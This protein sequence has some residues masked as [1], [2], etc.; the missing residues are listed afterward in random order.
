MRDFP[1]P[2]TSWIKDLE[3][4]EVRRRNMTANYSGLG[5][6]LIY[7]AIFIICSTNSKKLLSS[8]TTALETQNS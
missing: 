2:V 3:A 6:T 7:V 8:T 4:A 1:N 5:I